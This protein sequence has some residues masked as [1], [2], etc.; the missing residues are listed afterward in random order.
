MFAVPYFVYDIYAMFMCYWYKLQVKG[1]EDASATPKHMTSALTSYLR[2][3]FLMVLHHVVMVTV[4]FPVSVVTVTRCC[5][6]GAE[7]GRGERTFR[8]GMSVRI[9]QPRFSQTRSLK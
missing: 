7:T 3:E 4:C 1:H 5:F 8:T 6:C 2:R 9:P